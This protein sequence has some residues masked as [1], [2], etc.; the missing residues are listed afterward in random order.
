LKGGGATHQRIIMR[1][2]RRHLVSLLAVVVLLLLLLAGA[3]R[4]AAGAENGHRRRR[5]RRTTRGFFDSVTKNV[6][7]M[8]KSM[9]G[10][11][12]QDSRRCGKGGKAGHTLCEPFGKFQLRDIASAASFL[13]CCRPCPE[14]FGEDL[15]LLQL[16]GHAYDRIH[17]AATERF[18]EILG[19]QGFTPFHADGDQVAESLPCCDICPEH[20][21]LP[22]DY[23]DISDSVSP[24]ARFIE[25][26]EGRKRGRGL[27]RDKGGGGR[28]DIEQG[29]GELSKQWHLGHRGKKSGS[30]SVKGGGSPGASVAATGMSQFGAGAGAG[31][32]ASAASSKAGAASSAKAGAASSAKAGAASASKEGDAQANFVPPAVGG[33]TTSGTHV[34]TGFVHAKGQ[35]CNLCPV[36][37]VP[38]HYISESFK[39]E[40]GAVLPS[41]L[42]ELRRRGRRMYPAK[43]GS[44]IPGGQG[45][46]AGGTQCCPVCP[47]MEHLV[48]GAMAPF[49]GPFGTGRIGG[50]VG[51]A[52]ARHQHARDEA[53]ENANDMNAV[54][55]AMGDAASAV[56]NLFRI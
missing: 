22:M 38:E 37:R 16:P 10:M 7:T 49:G 52:M 46:M 15:A 4:R 51:A 44:G 53:A 27:D 24:G 3:P 5:R 39:P 56:S 28:H 23:E 45:V 30:S 47:T 36:E 18:A 14:K 19:T 33:M 48:N 2:L 8:G 54:G 1:R 42:I 43:A 21:F 32:G 31:A 34:N 11:S 12:A 17:A 6:K 55:G 9:L 25:K 26:G 29:V 20:F 13:G 40:G 41:F 50:A 35:C